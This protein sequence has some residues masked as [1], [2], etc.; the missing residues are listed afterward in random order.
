MGGESFIHVS[1]L[2]YPLQRIGKQAERMAPWNGHHAPAVSGRIA[3]DLVAHQRIEC[4]ATRCID[5][6]LVHVIITYQA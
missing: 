6:R 1:A 4:F 3:L 2:A 5:K